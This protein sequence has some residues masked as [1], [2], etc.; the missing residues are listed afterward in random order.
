LKAILYHRCPYFPSA[1]EKRAATPF[2]KQ[3]KL[4]AGSHPKNWMPIAFGLV[5]GNAVK[6]I[7]PEYGLV[8]QAVDEQQDL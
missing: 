5:S 2:V 8:W 6:N 7:A 4:R 1:A 3:G